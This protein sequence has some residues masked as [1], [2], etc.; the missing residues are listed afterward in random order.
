MFG[1]TNSSGHIA[2]GTVELFTEV[3]APDRQA[4]APVL[5]LSE[6][7]APSTR[8]PASLIDGLVNSGVAVIKF[9]TRDVGRSTWVD[10]EYRIDDLAGDA[11]HVLDELQVDSAHVI[12]R[13][14]GGIVAQHLALESPERVGAL[15]L[16]STTPGRRQDIGGPEDWLIERMSKRLFEPTPV[17]LVERVDWVVDQLEWFSGPLFDFD[18]K[19]AAREVYGEV[20][21]MWRGQNGHG[22]AVVDAPD[23]FD[24]LPTVTTPTIVIHGT[25]DPVYPVAHGQVLASQIPTARLHLIE[26]LGHELP[27]RFVPQLLEILTGF[28]LKLA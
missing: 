5:L 20:S 27:D 4:G 22:F 28:R 24:S 17:D 2:N 12:G 7:E 25:A 15:T 3:I 10:E 18:R 11:R 1:L 6:A 21:D 8:W 26:G 23:H 14:M 19:A 9:D 13:S 16:I